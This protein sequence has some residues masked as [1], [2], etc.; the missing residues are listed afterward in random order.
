MTSIDDIDKNTIDIFFFL[1]VKL[2]I[3]ITVIYWFKEYF[4]KLFSF[5]LN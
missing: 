5:N 1:I 4:I 3:T 2:K